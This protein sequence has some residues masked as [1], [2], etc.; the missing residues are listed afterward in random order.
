MKLPRTSHTSRPLR[1]HGIAGDFHLEDVW[2]LPTPGGPDDLPRLVRLFTEGELMDG[3][4]GAARLLFA[5]RWKLGKLFG[6]DEPGA[7]LGTRVPTLRHRLP[8]DLRDT[9]PD[10]VLGAGG[11]RPL[12]AT[13]DEWAAEMANSTVH[14]ILHLSWV[15]VP[16]G[17]H[18]GRM[19]V[20]VRPNGLFGTCY[21]AAIKPFR[22]AVVYPALLRAI[23]R[24]WK[25]QEQAPPGDQAALRNVRR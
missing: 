11:F 23:G 18:R 17:G 25:R 4:S 20:L 12:Y 1:I 8:A 15:P 22:Y 9:V 3:T 21:M 13:H 2:D 19:A 14:G 24:E 7:G 6:W 16:G 10:A 5:I